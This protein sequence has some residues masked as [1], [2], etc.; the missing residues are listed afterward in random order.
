MQHLKNLVEAALFIAAKPL[1]L[2]ELK[3]VK[4]IDIVPDEELLGV[5]KSMEVDYDSHGIKVSE[6]SGR[7]E[8]RIKDEFIKHVEHLAPNR[9]FSRATLQT[10]SLIAYKSPVKQSE[11][12]E[13]RGNRAYDHIKDLI[14]KSFIKSEAHG[15]TNILSITQKFLDYFSL[16]NHEEVKSYFAKKIEKEDKKAAKKNEENQP[17]EE[18]NEEKKNNNSESNEPQKT[19][20]SEK[21]N[22]EEHMVEEF[23][24]NVAE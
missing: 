9:D 7:F 21:F 18:N 2:E 1:T 23:N 12:I 13:I 24:K 8:L 15:H 6:D 11:I 3:K 14:E 20:E 22:K 10:L 16:K 19:P 5:L 4:G 17:V